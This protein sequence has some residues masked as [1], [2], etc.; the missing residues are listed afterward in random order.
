MINMDEWKAIKILSSKG[1]SIKTIAKQLKLS[2][3]TV[4][5]YLRETGQPEYNKK[6]SS[7]SKSNWEKYKELIL[8]MYHNKKFIGSRIFEELTKSGASGSRTGFY[9][10]FKSIKKIDVLKNIRERFETL[11]GKQAQFD[12]SEY[13]VSIGCEIR[14]VYIIIVI[15]GFSRYR[16]YIASL[17]ITQHSIF[18]AIEKCFEYFGYCPTEL[19]MDN[20]RQM[21]DNANR[22]MFKWN[23]KFE[24]F[25]AYYK[26]EPIACKVR[27]AWTKGK[28]ENP[29]YYL[30]NHFVKGNSFRDFEELQIK[31]KE[32]TEIVNNRHHSGIND[33]PDKRFE[34][35]KQYL[36]TLPPSYFISMKEEWRQVNYDSILSFEGN[37]YSVPYLYASKNVWVRKL[38]GYKIQVY[39][40][41]GIIIAEHVIPK[42]KGHI[43]I[44][45]KHYE[46]LRKLDPVS[47]PMIRDKFLSFFPEYILFLEKLHS[48]KKYHF[49]NHLG[50][51]VGLKE[52]YSIENIKKALDSCLDYNVFSYDYVYAYLTNNADIEQKP[53]TKTSFPPELSCPADMKRD[54]SCYEDM[55]VY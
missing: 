6:E 43:I 8:N 48:Q 15:L 11:P 4:K 38:L 30:E 44:E 22:K 51:I 17:D 53:I 37:K 45:N 2:K 46:G 36:Q 1:V 18:E 29:F 32:F 27:H 5:K 28:V 52:I 34:I 10:Y 24:E 9:E 55:E 54:L 47:T 39:S 7:I 13:T 50:R 33:V 26:V 41:K 3:N 23:K 42:G 16:C 31:L 20:A 21:V 35:E 49:K 25:L 19:L 14:K 40:Q 12:W